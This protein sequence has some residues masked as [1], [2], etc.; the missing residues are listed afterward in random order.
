M[1]TVKLY[2][3]SIIELK[4]FDQKKGL[5]TFYFASFET[6]DSD[7]DIIEQGAYKK[8]IEE[9]KARLKHFKNH[10][11]LQVPGV[12]TRIEE[13]TK[14]AF[15]TSQLAKTT[16]GRDTLIEYEAGIITEH[17]QGF[18]TIQEEFDTMEGVNRIKEIRLWEVSSL[19]HWGANENT[20]T[21]DVKSLSDPIKMFESLNYIL[22]KSQISDE[23]GEKLNELYNELGTFIK[24]LGEDQPP[25]GTEDK[26]P[27]I[28]DVD[29]L[30]SFKSKLKL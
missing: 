25:K 10:N 8:T 21:V 23:R 13:D 20:P 4:D 18:N 26:K 30:N 7:N 5:V 16:L 27:I 15:S 28:E 17:S 12:I 19:T 3:P 2:K 1:K 11:P 29:L 24:S 14:G 22:H 6:R 9:N